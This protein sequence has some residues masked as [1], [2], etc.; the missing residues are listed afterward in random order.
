MSATPTHWLNLVWWGSARKYV[1]YNLFVTLCSVLFFRAH[2]WSK[3]SWTYLQYLW[4]KTREI[5]QGCAFWG[6]CPKFSPTPV[7]PKFRK[8]CITKAVFRAKHVAKALPGLHAFTGCD[9][10]SAFVRRGK[11]APFKL[12]A[13]DPGF[14]KIFQQLG[15]APDCLTSDMTKALEHF[16]CCFMRHTKCAAPYFRHVT[17]LPYCSHCRQQNASVLT[18]VYCRHVH[19]HCGSTACVPTTRRWYGKKHT[20]HIPV[21]RNLK[22]MDGVDTGMADWWSIGLRVTWCRI[23]W[24]ILLPISW[25]TTENC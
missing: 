11:K 1:K 4:L 9:T 17:E 14:V 16:V 23:Q 10:T 18:L 12:M 25:L 7:S 19:P 2:T 8:F 5:R 22:D 3:N 20:Y 24:P 6:F 15:T 21:C 13:S